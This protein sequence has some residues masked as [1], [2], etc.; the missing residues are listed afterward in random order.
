MTHSTPQT[1]LARLINSQMDKLE[2]NRCILVEGLGFQNLDKT[3]RRL[4]TLLN[5]G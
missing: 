2:I 1:P 3:L 4:D 5:R